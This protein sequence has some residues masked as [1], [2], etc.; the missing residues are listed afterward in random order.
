MN[1]TESSSIATDILKYAS[2]YSITI[3]FITIVAGIIGNFINLLVIMSLKI[4][5]T[6]R[7]VFYLIIETISDLVYTFYYLTYIL[8]TIFY[9]TGVASTSIIWCRLQSVLV[10]SCALITYLSIVSMAI[11]QFISTNHRLSIRQICTTHLAYHLTFSI[12]IVSIIH[13]IIFC[14]YLSIVP[15]IGCII[16]NRIMLKYATFVFYPILVAILPITIASLF[17]ALA[18]RNV[19]HIIRLQL[20]TQRRQFDRQ[21][22]AMILLRVICFVFFL[23]PYIIYRIYAINANIPSEDSLEYAAIQLVHILV[24]SL[25]N[26]NYTV[27]RLFLFLLDYDH[28]RI[29][30]QINFYLFFISSKQY[31]CQVK[32]ALRKQIWQRW[33]HNTIQP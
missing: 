5:R 11:D 26:L 10:Q 21:I 31:R 32:D 22:T 9:P 33:R 4:F 6:N 18:Y 30:F 20:P 8:F 15:T 25:V 16:S 23:L 17:S 28:G 2:K 1:S 19:R 14:F 29:L 12:I 13:S 24:I 7:C 27:I 3:G